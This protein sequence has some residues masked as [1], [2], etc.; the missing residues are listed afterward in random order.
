[1][2]NQVSKIVGNEQIDNEV[3][4]VGQNNHYQLGLGHNK[5]VNQ[6]VSFNRYN[7]K[8][9]VK[10]IIGGDS[11]VFITTNDYRYFSAGDNNLRQSAIQ[12]AQKTITQCSENIYFNVKSIKIKKIYTSHS[13]CHTIWQSMTNKIYA[14]G[15]NFSNQC[16]IIQFEETNISSPTLIHHAPSCI[17]DIAMGRSHTLILAD[18]ASI[19]NIDYIISFWLRLISS[20]K[21]IPNDVIIIIYN[22]YCMKGAV[23]STKYAGM[24]NYGQNGAGDDNFPAFD[25]NGFHKIPFFK[26]KRITHIAATMN[27]SIFVDANNILWTVGLNTRGQLGLGHTEHDVKNPTENIYF[28]MNKIKIKEISGGGY[29]YLVLGHNGI[30]YSWGFNNWGQCGIGGIRGEETIVSTPKPLDIDNKNR[31][32]KIKAGAWHNY[33]LSKDEKHFLFGHNNYNQ[34]T[35]KRSNIRNQDTQSIQSPWCI[36]DIF[37][38]LTNNKKNIKDIWVGN[39]VTWI[40]TQNTE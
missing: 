16:G 32:V 19:E 23:Y 10:D 22:Y 30:C 2:G 13:S 20:T 37:Y 1:M 18:D 17:S 12:N 33:V 7:E 27:S 31:I 40:I 4:V 15:N 24:G 38:E 35:L 5:R 21:Q 36:H 26:D 8:I 29:H 11:N 3:F 39:G 14:T 9:S 34:C 28:K 6:L 25:Y